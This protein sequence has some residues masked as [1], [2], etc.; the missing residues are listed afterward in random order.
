MIRKMVC[1]VENVVCVRWMRV[2]CVCVCVCVVNT[3]GVCV[4]DAT[5]AKETKLRS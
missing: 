2:V 3:S 5:V 1:V 4:V